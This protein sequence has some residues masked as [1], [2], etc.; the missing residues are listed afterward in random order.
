MSCQELGLNRVYEGESGR[1]AKARAIEHQSAMRRRQPTSALYQ[2]IQTAHSGDE[3]QPRFKF[4]VR[5]RF[6]DALTRQ[7]EEGVRIEETE[8]EVLLNNKQEWVP[9]A[10]GRVRLE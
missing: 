8:E 7:V 5:Q 1:A 10:L 4:Q 3:N 6:K 9:P 2:H